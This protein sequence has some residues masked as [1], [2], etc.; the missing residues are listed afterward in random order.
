[1]KRALMVGK[2]T[3]FV[4]PALITIPSRAST[5]DDQKAVAALDTEYQA[6][7]KKNDAATM[8][9]IFDPFFT[10]KASGTGL[11][12]A[13]VSRIVEAHG[14]DVTLENG[15]AGGA[16]V[17]VRLPMASTSALARR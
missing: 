15:P 14:G 17:T 2:L 10:T 4:L 11:G 13:I 5:A 3:L 16:V 12:L 9:R 8:D 1:M 6:A 7:V